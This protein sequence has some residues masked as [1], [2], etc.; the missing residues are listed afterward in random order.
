[1]NEINF[2]EYG[3]AGGAITALIILVRYFLQ[4]IEKKD[5]LF[6]ETV[7]NHLT[8]STA[9]QEKLC[10]SVDKLCDKLND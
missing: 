2:L 7:N 10:S 9:V 4:H 8:H 3:V 5:R 1:M 6:S